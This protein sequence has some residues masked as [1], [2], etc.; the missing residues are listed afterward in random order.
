MESSPARD[1]GRAEGTARAQAPRSADARSR[2]CSGS[3]WSAARSS[4]PTRSTARSTSIFTSTVQE[5]R[6]RRQRQDRLRHR[7]ERERRP[8]AELPRVAAR[9]DPARSPT[10]RAAERRVTD[11][12]AARRPRRQGRRQRWRPQPRLQ[13]RPG[14]RPAFQPAVA[15][16]RHLAARPEPGRD[17]HRHREQGALCGRR[18]IGIQAVARSAVP[19]RRDREVRRASRSAAPRCRSS[20][21]PPRRRLF[22]SAGSSTDRG[23]VA[24]PAS[25]R[26]SCSRRSSRSC[27]PTSRRDGAAQAQRRRTRNVASSRSS[28]TSCSRFAAIALFVGSFVIA[29]TLS[30]TIAQRVRE[31]ATL[32]TLGATRRQILRPSSSR[33]SSIGT[34]AS[35]VGLFLGLG[36]AK[37]SERP[38]QRDRLRPA[39]TST[40]FATRTV[41]V[42]LLVGDHHHAAREPAPGAA[43]DPGAADRGRARGRDAPARPLRAV[44]ADSR[45]DHLRDRSSA[46][47]A[48]RRPRRTGC[49]RRAS[50]RARLR[51][52]AALLRRLLECRAPRAAARLRPRLAG[53]DASAALPESSP[54]T[55]RCATRSAPPPPR[56]R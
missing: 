21:S 48:L 53:N 4:S 23:R 9:E 38:V 10:S 30:I 12:S 18:P 47:L 34:I 37:G 17:R 15:H 28:S 35:I 29:N 16:R 26:R 8:A 40:V 14:R 32:R 5:C 49:P 50:V 36:L 20:T 54:A 31:F 11:E 22:H 33:R 25:R 1:Q 41:V 6:R 55:T 7:Y 51:R 46:L 13:R 45:V 52:R 27:L 43:R 24:K 42:S 3:R 39:D 19:G 44:H 56:L 2:S